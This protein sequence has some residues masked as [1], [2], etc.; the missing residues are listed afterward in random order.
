MQQIKTGLIYSLLIK[1]IVFERIT[2][3]VGIVKST[4]I[5][6]IT[7]NFSFDWPVTEK[8]AASPGAIVFYKLKP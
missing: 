4:T 8:T 6:F 1:G 2:W 5:Y 3:F 7:G